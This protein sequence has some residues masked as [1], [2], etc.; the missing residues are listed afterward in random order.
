MSFN[1]SGKSPEAKPH[2][3][4]EYSNSRPFS[5][6]GLAAVASLGA[7]SVVGGAW[8]VLE[9][10]TSSEGIAGPP[11]LKLVVDAIGGHGQSIVSASEVQ[12]SETHESEGGLSGEDADNEQAVNDPV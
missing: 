8:T 1:H 10:A 3:P 5:V 12:A 4:Y 6:F 7:L 9:Q 2:A 11:D